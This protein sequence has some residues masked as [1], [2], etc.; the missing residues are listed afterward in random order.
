[1]GGIRRESVGRVML[2][3]HFEWWERV[4]VPFGTALEETKRREKRREKSGEGRERERKQVFCEQVAFL[5]GC[6]QL[7]SNDHRRRRSR[8]RSESWQRH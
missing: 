8:V 6:E 7:K 2:R 4:Q 5:F 3:W 1:M